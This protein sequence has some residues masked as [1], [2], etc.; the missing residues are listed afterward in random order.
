MKPTKLATLSLLLALSAAPTFAQ[1]D[2]GAPAGQDGGDDAAAS[3][4][5]TIRAVGIYNVSTGGEARL[6]FADA[7]H[8]TLTIG[9]VT[10]AITSDAK[11]TTLTGT[12]SGDMAAVVNH[13]AQSKSTVQLTIHPKNVTSPDGTV[14]VMVTTIDGTRDGKPISLTR[15]IDNTIPDDE[16]S[17]SDPGPTSDWKA[18]FDGVPDYA[19]TMKAAGVD[20]NGQMFWYNFGPVFYRGRLDGTARVMVI[21]SDPGPEECL[22]FV[23]HPMV[24][25]AGQRV[26]GFLAKLGI[27]RSYILVNAY[28]Y[29][30]RPS[31]VKKNFGKAIITEDFSGV[32]PP[33]TLTDAQKADVHKITTWRNEFFTRVA[34]AS[35][36]QAIVPMG[37][38]AWPA[39]QSWIASLPADDPIRK[40]PVFKVQH[41]SAVDRD[42]TAPRPDTA[43]QGW[44]N[45]IGKLRGVVTPDPG[46]SNKGP[47][48][49][50][51]FTENDYA[52]IPR[53]D[54][55]KNAPLTVGNN[56]G[57]RQVTG[58]NNDAKRPSP[59]DFKSL[60]YTDPKTGAKT[61]Y[62]FLNGKFHPELTTDANGKPVKLDAN[63][64]PVE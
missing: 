56:V 31:F 26:Q 22:P 23:R 50:Q 44:Q 47:N 52:R 61:K 13:A 55:P 2:P 8:G 63:G 41:P 12:T 20:P 9:K 49:G 16:L 40:I 60:V 14:F 34:R 3:A 7:E 17:Q 54:L 4:P 51:Y 11:H 45:A 53:W 29:A 19:S 24:G 59:D 58:A 10:Y 39:Y 48:Y 27:D 21:A 15:R 30:M 28:A 36:L 5:T 57:T 64:L 42:P 33:L 6:D 62:V 18:F 38:N 1:D 35:K 46:Q 43:L 37:G 32:T 25:D